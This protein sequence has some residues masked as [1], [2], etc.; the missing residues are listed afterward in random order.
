MVGTSDANQPVAQKD[1]NYHDC[2]LLIY[3]APASRMILH[4]HMGVSLNRETSPKTSWKNENRPKPH[5]MGESPCYNAYRLFSVFSVGIHRPSKSTIRAEGSSA[6]ELRS[7]RSSPR[8]VPSLPISGTSG[9]VEERRKGRCPVR[10]GTRL[11]REKHF[12]IWDRRNSD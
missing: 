3:E 10:A 8:G 11:P 7:P 6:L 12:F 4:L 5:L 2:S 1:L 9:V